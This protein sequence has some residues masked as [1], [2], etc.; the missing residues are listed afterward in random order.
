[1]RYENPNMEVTKMKRVDVVCVSGL[2]GGNGDDYHEAGG[3]HS[4][5]TDGAEW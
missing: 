4:T 2:I 1:M 5:S 3:G